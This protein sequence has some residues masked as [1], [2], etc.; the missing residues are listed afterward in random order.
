M[1]RAIEFPEKKPQFGPPGHKFKTLS[2]NLVDKRDETATNFRSM[3]QGRIE[4]QK[5]KQAIR[6]ALRRKG[7]RNR[8]EGTSTQRR[9]QE[10]MTRAARRRLQNAR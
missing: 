3:K 4:D 8:T 10:S 7:Y 9:Q 2:K 1:A 5:N 6:Y